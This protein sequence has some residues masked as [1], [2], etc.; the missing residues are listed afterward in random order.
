MSQSKFEFDIQESRDPKRGQSKNMGKFDKR[1]HKNA[2]D[3]V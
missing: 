2:T 1:L 3:T